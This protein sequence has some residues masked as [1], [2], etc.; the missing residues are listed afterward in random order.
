MNH[1]PGSSGPP[2][3][4]RSPQSYGR[5]P[6]SW[7]GM[8][9]VI[10]AALLVAP[11]GFSEYTLTLLVVYALLALSLAFVWGI[12]GI[13]CF[14]QGAFYGL[15]AYAYAV[16][17]INFGESTGA[18]L[19]A[20][21]LSAAFAL[22][23]GAMMFYGRIGDVYL[24]AITLVATLVLFKYANSTAGSAYVIG[25]ARLGGFN[26]IPGFPVLNVPGRPDLPLTGLALYYVAAVALLGAWWLCRWLIVTPFG[27]LL[28]GIRENELR[29]E[30]SGYDVRVAKTLAFGIGGA[31]AGAAG[32]LFACWAEIVTPEV[33]S[34]GVS[35]EAIIWVLAGGL[36]TLAGPMLGAVLLGALKGVLGGQH[37]VNNAVVMGLLL[38]AVVLFLPR[39]VLPTMQRAA[40]A[41]RRRRSPKSRPEASHGG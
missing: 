20:I 15:G 10:G 1:R 23:L 9:L 29:A 37:L 35:A 21:G 28:A 11:L 12:S 13:L 22:A 27:R 24:G 38:I 14:G 40:A 30:L 2:V 25:T 16:G 19:L 39:G 31:L 17:A 41:L 32:V 4:V 34:L 36:G 26:G 8:F 18:A 5:I 6:A 33:F 3:R 7:W